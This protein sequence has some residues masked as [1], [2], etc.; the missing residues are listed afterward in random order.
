MAKKSKPRSKPRAKS[1]KSSKSAK[2]KKAAPQL[3]FKERRKKSDRRRGVID[4]IYQRLVKRDIIPDR[5][6]GD[7]RGDSGM[8]R[9]AN[10]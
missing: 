7:R 2:A 6:K 8:R 3:Q 10:D 4:A 5:R 9:R 1:A